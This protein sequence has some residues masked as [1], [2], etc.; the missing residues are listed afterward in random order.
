MQYLSI[1]LVIAVVAVAAICI[2]A[3]LLF[4]IRWKTQNIAREFKVRSRE[5]GDTLIID[6]HSCVYRGSDREYGN[7]KGNGNASV[8]GS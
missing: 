3:V 8:S 7:I 4:W 1:S 5:M 6:P 2:W